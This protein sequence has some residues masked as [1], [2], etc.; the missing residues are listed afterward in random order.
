VTAR[1]RFCITCMSVS[2]SKTVVVWRTWAYKS[3]AV[4]VGTL[5]RRADDAVILRPCRGF[6]PSGVASSSTTRLWFLPTQ[7][8]PPSSPRI[9]EA[10][11]PRVGSRGRVAKPTSSAESHSPSVSRHGLRRGA[12]LIATARDRDQPSEL[13]IFR[14]STL[15]RILAQVKFAASDVLQR[16]L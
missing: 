5:S 2:K 4:H 1:W 6:E 14:T 15:W 8:A 12:T 7:I 9:K 10:R 3:G 13:A 11:L 16:R